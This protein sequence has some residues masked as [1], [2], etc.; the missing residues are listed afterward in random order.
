MRRILQDKHDQQQIWSS[1]VLA[2]EGFP[3]VLIQGIENA[4]LPYLEELIVQNLLALE[5]PPRPR[6][7]L[8]GGPT[9][10]Y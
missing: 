7:A 9:F 3:E 6:F 10:N 1:L 2:Y 5:Q 8:A 4:H